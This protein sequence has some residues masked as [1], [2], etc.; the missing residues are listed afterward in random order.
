MREN[1]KPWVRARYLDDKYLVTMSQSEG[2]IICLYKC[3]RAVMKL[4]GDVAEAGVLSGS[5]ARVLARFFE[6]QGRTLHLFDTFSK[7]PSPDSEQDRPGKHYRG[8]DIPL[9]EVKQFLKGLENIEFHQG[10]FEQTLPSVADRKF[11]FVHIDCNLYEGAKQCCEFFY[12]RMVT[13]GIMLFHDYGVENFP[14]I[15]KAV[16]EFFVYKADLGLESVLGIHF[17]VIK[18]L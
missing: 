14:G 15:K 10:L 4:E 6:G 7:R 5:T 2:D 16:D 12:P 18:V 3:A 17:I 9:E 13:G 1:R 8:R 11:C